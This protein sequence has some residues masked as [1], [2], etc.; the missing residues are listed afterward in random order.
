MNTNRTKN[1]LC[2]G[3]NFL[4]TFNTSVGWS[5]VR[6]THPKYLSTVPVGKAN[7]EGRMI[8]DQEGLN[9]IYLETFL[10]CLRYQPIRPDLMELQKIKLNCLKEYWKSVKRNKTLPWQWWAQIFEYLNILNSNKIALEYYLYLYSCHFSRM[11][12]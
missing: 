6:K 10:W 9:K 4:S 3:S 1:Y 7:I 5:L 8:T 11:N 2:S 12:I